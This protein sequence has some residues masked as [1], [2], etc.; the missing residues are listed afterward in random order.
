M[1]EA[2]DPEADALRHRAQ[3]ELM[4]IART[5]MPFGRFQGLR[6]HELPAEYLQWFAGKGWP[7][8]RLGVLLRIVYQMKA[9]GSDIAFDPFRGKGHLR[10][11]ADA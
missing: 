8:G 7:E 4:E 2:F 5:V 9:D 10:R 11:P 3:D 1:S 6:L